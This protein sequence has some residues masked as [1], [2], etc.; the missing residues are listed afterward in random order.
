MFLNTTGPKKTWVLGAVT[1]EGPSNAKETPGPRQ[2]TDGLTFDR[3]F[4]THLPKMPSH[5]CRKD[6]QKINHK[7]KRKIKKSKFDHLQALKAVLPEEVHYF[8]DT[9]PHQ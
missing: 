8:Y 5:C 9:L 4:L 2:V 6:T 3:E 7:S 1:E